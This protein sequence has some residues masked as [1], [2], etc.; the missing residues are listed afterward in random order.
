MP[1]KPKNM[2]GFTLIELMVVIAIIAIIALTIPNF[3]QIL[4]DQRLKGSA[5]DIYA[6]MQKAKLEA[7]RQNTNVVFNFTP[8]P[9]FVPAGRAGSYII[10]MDN[11]AGGGTSD[12][13]IQ[14]GGEPTMAS[15]TMPKNVT[16]INASFTGGT[17][18]AGFNSRG[19][20]ANFR[21]GNIQVRN[22]TR[23]YRISLS[24]AGNLQMMISGDGTDPSWQ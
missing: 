3:G 23:W 5:R 7:I 20:P 19:L 6:N 18:V 22:A 17:S 2:K 1:G 13:F 14:N 12:D 8:A 24:I 9:A 4:A 10:F 21:I 15:V 16:M 11:G